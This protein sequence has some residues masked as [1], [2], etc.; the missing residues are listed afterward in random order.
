MVMTHYMELL[1]LH[2][3]WFLILFML[4]P[5]VLAETILASEAFSLINHDQHSE[6]WDN[7][8]H[9]C[10]IILGIFFILAVVYIVVSYVPTIDWRGPI[11]YI[12]IW[13]YVLGIIPAVLLLLGELGVIFKGLDTKTKNKRHIVI[14][15]FFILFT[16]L[17][18]V[19][20]MADPQLAGYVPPKQQQMNMNMP[21][22]DGSQMNHDQMKQNQNNGQQMN[23]SQMDHSQM[24]QKDQ[25]GQ[26][27]MKN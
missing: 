24:Q 20:G 19:F 26:M 6:K 13:A 27:D 22:S 14:M 9:V 5:M 16:H 11:D 21:M 17:A 25:K 23:H 7:L 1:S 2:Q 4:V 8:S 10:G 12:S 3:P 15:I 18:M